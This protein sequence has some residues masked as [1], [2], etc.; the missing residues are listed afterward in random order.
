MGRV[1]NNMGASQES[2]FC[3]AFEE[4]Q[5]SQL[6]LPNFIKITESYEDS[7]VNGILAVY[8]GCIFQF[9]KMFR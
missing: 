6:R 9:L 8:F 3:F 5:S 2:H 4:S 7:S 1:F